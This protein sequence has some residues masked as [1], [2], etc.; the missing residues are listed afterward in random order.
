MADDNDRKMQH[1]SNLTEYQA[2]FNYAMH[3]DQI[4]AEIGVFVLKIMLLVNAGGLITLMG[5][6][7]PLAE[8]PK[9]A[10][11]LTWAGKYFL[12]ALMTA[13]IA[14]FISYF[15][16]GLIVE[17]E[18]SKMQ[19][20]FEKKIYRPWASK[21]AAAVIWGLIIPGIVASFVL[22]AFGA[23]EVLNTLEML[24]QLPAK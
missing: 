15:Y 8:T 23:Y 21:V 11:G 2:H 10:A 5:V 6:Y 16:Q 12:W 1:Q 4:A 19:L 17:G 22:F 3:A 24:A 14:A 20:K 13:M 18:W 9:I 7:Q